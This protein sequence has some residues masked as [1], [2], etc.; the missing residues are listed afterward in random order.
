VVEGDW[1]S[2]SSKSIEEV[3]LLAGDSGS[4]NP[5][6]SFSLSLRAGMAEKGEL[7]EVFADAALVC[8]VLLR[9]GRDRFAGFLSGMELPGM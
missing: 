4:F 8:N 5:G 6:L 7:A 9:S 3:V 1:A 2:Q